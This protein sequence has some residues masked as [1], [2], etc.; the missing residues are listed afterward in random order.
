MDTYVRDCTFT[1]EDLDND[2][3]EDNNNGGDDDDNDTEGEEDD[4]NSEKALEISF[5]LTTEINNRFL[6]NIN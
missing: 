3:D 2:D 1:L 4:E 6:V 5:R